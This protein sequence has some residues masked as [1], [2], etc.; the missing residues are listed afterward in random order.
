MIVVTST[1]TPSQLSRLIV[2]L[3][4][5][6]KVFSNSTRIFPAPAVELAPVVDIIPRRGR[7]VP[8]EP[9]SIKHI[10][11]ELAERTSPGVIHDQIMIVQV[12]RPSLHGHQI[13]IAI[14]GTNSSQI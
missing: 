4:P 7:R 12:Q 3:L 6:T 11:L 5:S 13:A 1:L 2:V 8:R 10:R 14:P 9:Q